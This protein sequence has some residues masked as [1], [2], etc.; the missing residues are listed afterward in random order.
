MAELHPRDLVRGFREDVGLVT[1]AADPEATW[2]KE[3]ATAAAA[4]WLGGIYATDGYPAL[5]AAL[6]SAVAGGTAEGEADALAAAADRQGV[7]GFVIG[8]A[9]S[10]ALVKA[11]GDPGVTQQAQETAEKIIGGA[12]A[13]IGRTLAAM[14]EDGGGEGEMAGAVSDVT[15]GSQSRSLNS[16]LP[17]ALWAAMG[18]GALALYSQA[19]QGDSTV[20]TDWITDGNPCAACQDNEA[21]SPYAPEDVPSYPQ[22]PRCQ[23]TLSTDSD[24]PSS[25]FAG[26]LS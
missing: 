25:F 24:I 8:T 4:A 19:S 14:A 5:A 11:Q 15:S 2:R 12:A 23:C 13:D 16:W 7:S 20:M 1:K 26:L 6:E 3:S 22:H 21:G 17:D 18:A 9:F 10:A